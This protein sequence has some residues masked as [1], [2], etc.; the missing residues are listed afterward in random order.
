MYIKTFL[1][2]IA[3]ALAFNCSQKT[4]NVETKESVAFLEETQ[5][6]NDSIENIEFRSYI[7]KDKEISAIP[8]QIISQLPKNHKILD[9]AS[10]KLNNDN[11]K[12]FIISIKKTNEQIDENGN[13]PNR[14]LMIFVGTKTNI[15]KLSKI[16]DKNAILG[17]NFGSNRDDPFLGIKIEKENFIIEHGVA[18]GS[19]HW[20]QYLKFQFNEDLDNWILKKDEMISFSESFEEGLKWD[21]EYGMQIRSHKVKTEKNFGIITIDKFEIK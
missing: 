12:D 10:G 1:L 11:Y 6:S 3:C 15:F 8:K 16:N 5:K 20:K 9:V 21:E 14:I 2:I 18:S 4:K 7:Y 13:Y 17:L 19:S